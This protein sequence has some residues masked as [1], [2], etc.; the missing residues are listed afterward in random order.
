MKDLD[1]VSLIREG[2]F[3]NRLVGSFLCSELRPDVYLKRF[4]I[5]KISE[6]L[7]EFG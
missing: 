5:G 1:D 4:S 3:F 6:T 7:L 2:L